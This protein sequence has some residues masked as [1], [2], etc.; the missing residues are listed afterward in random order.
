M[1]KART[2]TVSGWEITYNGLPIAEHASE[3]IASRVADDIAK[4]WNTARE[5][6][7]V[8]EKR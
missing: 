5:C 1:T 6:F 8:R 4:R 7:Q 3:D 2:V